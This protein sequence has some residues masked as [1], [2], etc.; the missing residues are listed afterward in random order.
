M[1]K[2]VLGLLLVAFVFNVNAQKQKSSV[3]DT[4]LIGDSVSY[5]KQHENNKMFSLYNGKKIRAAKS[6][7]GKRAFIIYNTNTAGERRISKIYYA[8]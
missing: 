5:P 6:D 2:T 8:N 1:K 4:I 7:K 3:K